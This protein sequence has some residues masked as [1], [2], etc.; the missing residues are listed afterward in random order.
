MHSSLQ[1]KST[2]GKGRIPL[3]KQW[4]E[5]GL[6]NNRKKKKRLQIKSL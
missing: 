1:G 6:K 4:K 2:K 3:I 5:K